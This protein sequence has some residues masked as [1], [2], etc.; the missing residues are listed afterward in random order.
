MLDMV[1][2]ADIKAKVKVLIVVGAV[3]AIVL[4]AYEVFYFYIYS[5]VLKH[6]VTELYNIL[7]YVISDYW[8]WLL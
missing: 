4:L 8:M 3:G 7:L 2:D 6:Y 1:A 5:K